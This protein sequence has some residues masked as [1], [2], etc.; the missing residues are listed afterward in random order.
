MPVCP[1]SN[2][3]EEE[4]LQRQ[5]EKK[6]SEDMQDNA[7]MRMADLSPG[8]RNGNKAS[9]APRASPFA[10]GACVRIYY[11]LSGRG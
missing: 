3:P 1:T 2:S 9:I 4:A 5:K 7:P 8:G 11:A 10:M 6:G